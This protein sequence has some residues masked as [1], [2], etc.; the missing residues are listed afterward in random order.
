M[1]RYVI[2][3]LLLMIPVIIGVAI[4]IFTIMYFIPGDPVKI[5]LGS[6]ATPETIESVRESMGYNDPYP[7]RLVTFLKNTFLHFDLGISYQYGTPVVE[8]LMGRFPR[9]LLIALG[10][11]ILS[12]LIGIPLGVASALNRDTW[13]DRVLMILAMIGVTMPA[14]WLALLLVIEF[15]LKL[16]WFPSFGIGSPMNY[17]LPI[18]ASSVGGIA[19]QAR[20]TRSSILE[21]A[22]ADF[23]TTARAKGL[24][25]RKIRWEHIFPN[26]LIPI[27]TDTGSRFG[28][29]L[30]GTLIIENVF[31]IFS[32]LI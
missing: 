11:I 9:T 19:G 21:Q 18:I 10:S 24:A 23:V 27:I 26:A 8:D 30:G 17:V 7:V 15:A 20:Q 31:S 6:E 25:E 16:G 13:I 2:K 4:L 14:F 29:M 32:C 28:H 5:M 22:K 12:L 1:I 3:R